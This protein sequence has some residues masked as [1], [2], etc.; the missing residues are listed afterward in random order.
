MVFIDYIKPFDNVRLSK[1]WNITGRRDVPKQLVEVIRSM[2]KNTEIIIKTESGEILNEL[3]NKGVKK[4]C[5]ISP[6]LFN[7]C[8]GDAVRE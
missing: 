4:R 2:Y 8:L 7:L 1:L 3:I 6:T 5:S